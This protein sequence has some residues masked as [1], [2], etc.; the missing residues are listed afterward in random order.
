MKSTS[1]QIA[2]EIIAGRRLNRADD[3]SFLLQDELEELCKGADE[4][5][6][7]FCGDEIDL[8]TIVNGR[9]GKCSEN[10]KFCAQSSHY[11]TGAEVHR[12]LEP[13]EIVLD[14]KTN[15]AEGV[16]RY[17]IV[18]AGRTLEGDDLEKAQEAYRRLS[19]ETK[20]H[21]CASHGLLSEEA[22]KSLKSAG[23]ERYHANIETSKRNFS[24]ICTTHTFEDKLAC[25]DRAKKAGLA[26]CS[27]GILGMGEDWE[28]RLDMAYTLSELHVDSIPLN[29]LIPIP[30]TPF[31]NR[32]QLKREEILRC[33]ALFRYLNPEA[34]IRL[35]AGRV[36]LEES[37]REA[38]ES[39]ANAAIT[40]NMLT[41]SGNTIRE[42]RQMIKKLGRGLKLEEM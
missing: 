19:H 14:A 5:R 18:T 28:D 30:G 20:L 39:G 27:G 22:F 29:V 11:H 34:D 32:E 10:C 2:G 41:T 33:V 7:Y 4:I 13:D 17:S 8:C 12:F 31:E 9:G 26:V 15:E 42:D 21:L 36:L 25:I 40:G 23:V 37:G 1:R 24:N 38:F 35:A 3:V 6:S 16:R